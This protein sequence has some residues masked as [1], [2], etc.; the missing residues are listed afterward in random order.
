MY[1]MRISWKTLVAV[2]ALFLVGLALSAA[3][4]SQIETPST[5][6]KQVAALSED[7]TG[8]LYQNDRYQLAFLYPYSW[9]LEERAYPSNRSTEGRVLHQVFLQGAFGEHLG[10]SIFAR[11]GATDLVTWLADARMLPASEGAEVQFTPAAATVDGRDANIWQTMET[12]AI[13]MQVVF[14]S[15]RYFYV[16]G[17]SMPLADPLAV[18]ELIESIAT[19]GN[20]VT[21][22][23]IEFGEAVGNPVPVAAC[24][25]DSDS[26]A[27]TYPCCP[28]YGNCTWKA[29]R[30]RSGNNN[31]YFSGS[32][33]DAYKWMTLAR[34][35][36]SYGQGGTIPAV[37]AVLVASDDVGSGL[38]HVGTVKQINSNG[39]VVL[40]EQNCGLTCTRDKTYDTTWLRQYLAGYIY[41][42]SSAPTP[43]AKSISSTGQTII[44]DY[45]TTTNVFNFAG[46][47]PGSFMSSNGGQRAWGRSTAG[48]GGCMHYV[49]S[50][51]GSSENYGRWRAT[52]QTAGLYEI[53]A[54]I[55]N[56]TLAAAT[57]V[58]YDVGGVLS[59][60]INQST[61]R[62]QWVRVRNPGRS[63]GYWN[64]GVGTY[65]IFLRDNANASA[66]QRIAFD[67]IKFIKR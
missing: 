35:Y 61:N 60:A 40:K 8:Q 15:D 54:W 26:Y 34:Q 64:L 28:T 52:I 11:T 55:P 63:D 33:R 21:E 9:T 10:I 47:G 19:G 37:G 32:G 7:P 4:P 67:A 46:Y 12:S 14:E 29:E 48:L 31:F 36:T 51:S 5:W 38:G 2:P 56:T 27:N 13:G 23:P 65:S 58:R 17:L 62:N 66:N 43:T 18:Q 49:L 30:D 50:K 53:Q 41:T 59:L 3:V 6:S 39:S 16:V 24:C 25:S 20:G 57:S 1:F 45:S 42:G 22:L 44:E